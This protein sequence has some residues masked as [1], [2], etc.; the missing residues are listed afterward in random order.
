[1]Y[2]VNWCYNFAYSPVDS[3]C[4]FSI[5]IHLHINTF[6]C[7]FMHTS[8]YIVVV[9]A[10]DGGDFRQ[11]K[12]QFCILVNRRSIVGTS[13]RE[14]PATHLT[15][16]HLTTDYTTEKDSLASLHVHA[17]QVCDC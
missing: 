5:C 4:F 7:Q 9:A 11:C 17:K 1:M 14:E 8:R 16:S 10:K 6:C 13:V 3:L 12:I 2:Y 15:S